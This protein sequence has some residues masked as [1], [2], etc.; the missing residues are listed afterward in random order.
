MCLHEVSDPVS[1]FWDTVCATTWHSNSL[2]VFKPFVQRKV[3]LVQKPV[4]G[5]N[6]TQIGADSQLQCTSE[7][8][9]RL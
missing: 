5:E 7:V 8:S 2:A 1:P 6:R 9:V 4:G 3:D